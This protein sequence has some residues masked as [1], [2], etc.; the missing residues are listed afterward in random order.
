MT[1]PRA[2]S[3]TP[4]PPT[5]RVT[6]TG[7]AR[8]VPDQVRIAVAVEAPAPEVGEALRRVSDGVARLLEVL[9]E[10]GVPAADRSTTGVSVQP[11]WDPVGNRQEGHTASY[12]LAVLVRDLDAAGRL[13][14]AAHETGDVLRVHA[15]GL[16]VR[17][18][19]PA[20]RAIVTVTGTWSLGVGP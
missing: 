19:A 18:P 12:G 20:V 17:D 5:V 1:P 6:A 14:A 15:F 8:V 3:D 10:A 16:S 4:A 13:E 2:P 7:A 11:T 9:D